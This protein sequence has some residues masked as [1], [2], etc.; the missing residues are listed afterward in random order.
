M[1]V[2]NMQTRFPFVFL[3]DTRTCFGYHDDIRLR[4]VINL[5]DGDQKPLHAH[6]VI[7]FPYLYRVN[8]MYQFSYAQT[9]LVFA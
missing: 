5:F 7:L 4:Y 2:S 3:S 1:L 9:V 6:F 8:A